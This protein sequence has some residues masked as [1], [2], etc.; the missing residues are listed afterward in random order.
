M[1][2]NRT[3]QS[4]VKKNIG[5]VNILSLIITSSTEEDMAKQE[6]SQRGSPE[7]QEEDSVVA[8]EQADS[9]QPAPFLFHDFMV[10]LT[11]CLCAATEM[12]VAAVNTLVKHGGLS[13]DVYADMTLQL[14]DCAI[15]RL[16]IEPNTPALHCAD[17]NRVDI[18]YHAACA[19]N[20][21]AL[22]QC[23]ICKEFNIG[24]FVYDTRAPAAIPTKMQEK[25]EIAFEHT[26]AP[27]VAPDA[28][29]DI[30][31]HRCEACGHH[32]VCTW[33]TVPTPDVPPEVYA[34]VGLTLEFVSALEKMSEFIFHFHQA[35]HLCIVTQNKDNMAR[36]WMCM[37]EFV[38]VIDE[39]DMSYSNLLD[40]SM[41]KIF[42][43]IQ[44]D[45]AGVKTQNRVFEPDHDDFRFQVLLE[46][47]FEDL[48]KR[49]CGFI[50]KQHSLRK[51]NIHTYIA[52][53]L[54]KVPHKTDF[55][56]A[57]IVARVCNKWPQNV[58]KHDFIIYQ[59]ERYLIMKRGRE[60]LDRAGMH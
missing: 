48:K 53:H 43:I 25:E 55:S 7:A 30:N 10:D 16:P 1:V 40:L 2:Q 41:L 5:A 36:I 35:L 17:C 24:P 14:A 26:A 18:I 58:T 29:D 8:D 54:H 6:K 19:R 45:G 12:E 27:S 44:I 33:I 3:K 46:F 13:T 51:Y 38:E 57:E 31:L 47:P 15:C 50:E 21:P 49:I 32:H 52:Q 23:C 22:F 56:P 39:D 42:S 20:T 34:T 37:R 59:I 9:G 28:P 4:Q 11:G 60:V